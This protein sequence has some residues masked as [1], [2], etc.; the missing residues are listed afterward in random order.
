VDAGGLEECIPT[1]RGTP[2]H[3]AAWSRAWQDR[4]GGSAVVVADDF[5]LARTIR[6]EDGAVVADYRLSAVPG[7]SFVWAAHSLLDLSSSARLHAPAGTMTR[8]F[9]PAPWPLPLDRFGPDD[10]TAVG[11]ILVDCPQVSVSDGA[12]ELTF[13]LTA[14]GQPVSTALWRNLGGFPQPSPYR[15][16]GVEPMLGRVFDLAG[17]GPGDAAVVPAS[18]VCEW[19]LTI[20]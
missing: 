6:H 9:D 4:G 3:G 8:V 2:D 20:R 19:R 13:T 16:I 7:W 5:E 18:G 17:A 10:G 14:V 11:A 15:S 12:D 1:V